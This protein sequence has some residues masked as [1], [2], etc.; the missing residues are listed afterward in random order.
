MKTKKSTV[1]TSPLN[2][3]DVRTNLELNFTQWSQNKE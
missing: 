2:A 1:S 3:E